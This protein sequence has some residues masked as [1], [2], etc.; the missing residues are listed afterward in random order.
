MVVDLA[1]GFQGPRKIWFW[2]CVAA[3]AAHVNALRQHLL[4]SLS[5]CTTSTHYLTAYYTTRL[6]TMYSAPLL[7]CGPCSAVCAGPCQALLV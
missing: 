6:I 4:K 1:L 7:S 3:S 5:S 2:N